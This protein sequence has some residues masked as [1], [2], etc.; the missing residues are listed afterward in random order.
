METNLKRFLYDWFFVT[1]GFTA[2]IVCFTFLAGILVLPSILAAVVSGWFVLLY[3]AVI[4]FLMVTID[5]MFPIE[6][7]F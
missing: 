3:L 5:R 4:P 6:G 7:G 1:L 2:L